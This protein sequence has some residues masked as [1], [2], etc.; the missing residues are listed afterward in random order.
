MGPTGKLRP[1]VTLR[2]SS[3][4]RFL[5][6]T[7]AVFSTT[8]KAIQWIHFC[9]NFYYFLEIRMLV[10]QQATPDKSMLP[11]DRTKPRPA[12]LLGCCSRLRFAFD[13]NGV[14]LAAV[15]SVQDFIWL[16]LEHNV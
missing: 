7:P 9:F 2:C 6:P 14:A 3:A 12:C 10:L 15:K 1:P 16:A 13:L 5:G 4:P 8:Y 11:V